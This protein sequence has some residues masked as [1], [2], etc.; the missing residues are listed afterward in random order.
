MTEPLTI[1]LLGF[2]QIA[3][4]GRSLHFGSTKATA[5]LAYLAVSGMLHSRA[6]LAALLWPESDNKR[7]RGA[8]R[9]TL[10]LIKKEIGEGFLI[11]NRQQIG[12][13]PVAAWEVDVVQVRQFLAPALRPEGEL[14]TGQCNQAAQG[15]ALYQADFLQG[16]SL[17]DCENFNEWASIQADT[18]RRDVATALKHLA[19]AYQQRHNWEA[20]LDY[21]HRWL[22]FDSLHEPAHALL[23]QIYADSGQWTAV[24]NQYQSLGDLLQKEL[25]APPQP[26]TVSLYQQ[27]CQTRT[28]GTAAPLTTRTLEQSNQWVLMEKVRR[29]WVNGM[30]TPLREEETFIPLKLQ[31][32][33]DAVEH[34]WT[35]VIDIRQTPVPANIYQAFRNANRALLIMGTPGAGK[36]V[37]LVE[38]A[39]YLLAVVADDT[40][41]P[42]PVILNLS[43][44]AGKQVDIATW[45]VE[46]MVAKYQIPRR[47]GRDWLAQD[48]LLLLFDG[49]DEM[50]PV[51]RIECLVALNV[52]RQKHG[53]ADMVVCCREEAY[54]TAVTAN[55]TPLQLNGA[56]RVR[57][58]TTAQIRENIPL[59]LVDSLFADADL[60]EMAQ[61][62]LALNMIRLAYG[63]ANGDENGSQK[64]TA[65][66]TT[67]RHLFDIYVQRMLQRQTAKTENNLPDAD[68]TKHLSWLAQQMQRHNQSIFLIEQ[69]QPSWLGNGRTKRE[70]NVRSRSSRWQWLYLLLTRS[71]LAALLGTPIGWSFIQLIRVNPPGVEV[72]FL[73]QA[74]ALFGITAV[75]WNGLFS[76]FLLVLCTGLMASLVDGCFFTWRRRR[77]DE[78]HISRKLGWFQLLSVGGAVWLS[79]TAL[80]SLTDDWLLALS[81]GG[82]EAVGFVLSFGYLSY[83]QSWH[84]EV[85][86]R[87]ALTWSWR[88]AAQLGLLGIGLAFIWSGTAWL[89]DPNSPRWAANLI[90]TGFT[91]F[92]LG[93]VSG[94]RAEARDRP[95]E[96][97]WIAGQNGIKA[98]LLL[99]IPTALL[100][101]IT[102]NLISGILTGILYGTLAGIVHGF[103][104]VLKHL[105][106]RLLL[107][108][109]N[110]PIR[111]I[112]LLDYAADAILLQKVGGGYTF[113][114]RLLQE[115]FAKK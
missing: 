70:R 86:A 42:I 76:V 35:D 105:V 27:L 13:E 113:R 44:W 100:V 17:R 3:L 67:T 98:A 30:L 14:T 114:H 107:V 57:P 54:E 38:L 60:L 48:R 72:H 91:F 79:A 36:T 47:M 99:S 78:A 81:L 77:N 6:E 21:G 53:L 111:Y 12:L 34:P 26:E 37:S 61:T 32:V 94:K 41:Q 43:S 88:N 73:N 109:G 16:F 101:G 97:I 103:N 33:N 102:I 8:L 9:Y 58:L 115:Y 106:I 25:D 93:G 104:D 51:Y 62:P 10:S 89:Q 55:N 7:G 39:E 46:E 15:V 83:G 96:G 56:V 110:V 28:M 49:L 59:H 19:L 1:S 40:T 29:F 69:L 50:L 2:P 68:V 90:N 85:R 18:L 11:A 71:F 63:A 87:G 65:V 31:C 108:E 74:A 24:H 45:T 84:T 75:P 82:M 95:N 4:N 92:L 22:N 80:L 64:G 52:F 20:A 112:R 23:M 5:L 66:P